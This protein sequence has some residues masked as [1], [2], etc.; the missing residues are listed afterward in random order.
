MINSGALEKDTRSYTLPSDAKKDKSYICIDCSAKVIP[1]QGEIRKHHFAHASKTTCSFF[2]S[3]SE[4]QTHK[5]AKY[6]L[7]SLLKDKKSVIIFWSCG[8]R[9]RHKDKSLCGLG[10]GG[11]DCELQYEENDEVIV[12]Y[13]DKNNK[14]VA[15]IAVLN[16]DKVKYIFEIKYTHKVDSNN[17][18][19]PEPWFEIEAKVVLDTEKDEEDKKDNGYSF[20]CIRNTYRCYTCVALEDKTVVNLPPRYWNSPCINCKRTDYSCVWVEGKARSCCQICI[21]EV[22]PYNVKNPEE[23]KENTD[24]INESEITQKEENKPGFSSVI[25]NGNVRRVKT[26][27]LKKIKQKKNCRIYKFL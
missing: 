17:F 2:E 12:E 10:T 11:M 16:K 9:L 15:D 4:S 8:S 22:V 24:K 20:M 5:E 18:T 26:V 7:A 25:V 27:P 23:I 14:Y 1:K 21:H 13:R 6:K 19:R 3:H